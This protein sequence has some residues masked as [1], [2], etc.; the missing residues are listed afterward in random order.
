MIFILQGDLS[1]FYIPLT[2][3]TTDDHEYHAPHTSHTTPIKSLHKHDFIVIHDTQ[4]NLFSSKRSYRLLLRAA[5]PCDFITISNT[6]LTTLLNLPNFRN[7]KEFLKV[8]LDSFWRKT[9]FPS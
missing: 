6:N 4:I 8:R 9:L 5:S 2:D 1:I 7:L 3:E